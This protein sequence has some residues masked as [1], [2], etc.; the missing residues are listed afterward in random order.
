MNQ[1]FLL[2]AAIIFV[3]ILKI[4]SFYI[5]FVL[6][7]II[8]IINTF[9]WF[10]NK[11]M[12]MNNNKECI[13]GKNKTVNGICFNGCFDL[14]HITHILLYIIIGIIYPDNYL[15]IF[16]ISIIWEFYEDYMFKYII[17]NSN[18]NDI[19]CLRFEDIIL[20]LFGYF[21]GSNIEKLI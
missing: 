18:C 10:D 3:I 7:I 9:S 12:N 1:I 17:K 13:I 20:N 6:I 15:L 14:W 4:K 16:I 8:G 21:I 19:I 5:A 2:L 11:N